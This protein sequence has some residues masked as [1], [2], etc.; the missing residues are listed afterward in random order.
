MNSRL[1]GTTFAIALFAL[2]AGACAT[3]APSTSAP[4]AGFENALQARL[5]LQ[6]NL[7][8]AKNV[9][10]FI[11]D[12]MGLST[13]TAARIF[14]GQSAGQ[15]GEEHVLPFEYFPNVALVKTYNTNQQVSDSAGTATAM[16]SGIKTRAG[17]IA[18]GPEVERQDCKASL[19]KQLPSLADLA[20]ERGLATG[21][22]STARVTHATPATLYAHSPE[23]NWENDSQLP[24]Q[25]V[26]D[27]CRDIARQLVDYTVG[28]GIDVILGGGRREFVGT[29]LGGKRKQASADLIKDWLKQSPQRHFVTN[30]EELQALPAHGQVIGLFADSHM[31]YIL[32]RN[33]DSGEPSLPDMT[34]KAIELLSQNDEGFFLMVEGGRIDHGHH[35]GQAGLALREAQDFAQAVQTALASTNTSETLIVVTADHSHVF[36]IA[37]YP[38]RGNPI[39]GLVVSNDDAGNAMT[40][41]AKARDG[42]P[43]TTLGYH[44]GPGAMLKR[45]GTPTHGPQAVQLAAIPTWAETH[46]GEDVPLY[47]NGPRAHMF[48]GVI[49]QELIFHLIK[50]AYG[51]N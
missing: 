42:L 19:A 21:L 40:E 14:T 39:L 31:S 49:D 35:Q 47:A 4:E 32:E 25:A 38:T 46:A 22:V 37:G 50:H 10:L 6:P 9:I 48:G 20:E 27:G 18:I 2:A 24:P 26:A 51:W 17:V 29:A 34:R 1:Y 23:R 45:E 44:N 11:G 43:Y 13:V 41:P 36:T 16:H 12:G 15:Q 33:E 5:Q 7:N 8:K 30:N 28:D 3:E